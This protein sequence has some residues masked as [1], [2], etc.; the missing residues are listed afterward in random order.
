V[1]RFT[2]QKSAALLLFVALTVGMTWPQARHL[3]THVHD[4]D[5]SL[6]SIWRIAWIAHA[7]AN[8]PADLLDANIFH[9][10]SRTL[11]Y[12]DAVL[13]Q[14]VAAAPLIWSG[15]S[16]IATYNALILLSI[17]VSGW[18]M[19]LYAAR[20][21]GSSAAGV[22][23][24]VIYAFVPYRF[25][26][27]NHLEL[28]ATFFLPLSLL[29]LERLLESRTRRDAAW[30][31]LAVVGQVYSG[32]Y[33]AVFLTTALAIVV[34]L[35][36]TSVSPAARAEI[37]RALIAPTLV[38]IV[39]VVPY[40][41][42]Y[43]SN[44]ASLGERQDSEIAL[45]SATLPNYLAATPENVIHGG[46]SSP[47]GRSERRLFPGVIATA[48]AVVGLFAAGRR[49][50]TLAVCA[51]IGLVLSLGFNTPLYDWIRAVVVPYR[52]L[53]APARAAILVFVAIAGLAAYG[54]ARLMRGRSDRF[55]NATAAII[56]GALLIEYCAPLRSWLVLPAEP[57]RVYRWLASQPPIVVAEFPFARADRLDIIH[58]GVYMFNSI[59]H[60]QPIVNG[61]SGFFPRSFMEMSEAMSTFPDARAIDY[62]RRRGVDVI[63]VHGALL[64]ERQ[65]SDVTTAL[66]KHPDLEATA[67]FDEPGGTDLVFRLRR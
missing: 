32:I 3:S 45:Y 37:A 54:F 51:A 2:L 8:R 27:Y 47:L 30:L 63:V 7:L 39:V 5:D 66:L 12:S 15:V 19:W 65:R 56:T 13:L 17:A 18:A 60:W 52:G 11:A 59:Y 24:G 62:L 46:W 35:R 16:A 50:N 25:D 41:L 42:V 43:V 4:S 53:R 14:G 55:T 22:I 58:D 57:P 28:H 48:F 9:P 38:A 33:Y 61:Y 36:L 34:P 26:H 44:R 21:T 40:L 29:A 49:R 23:A 20:V 67:Q 10:E 6:L 1:K 31:A 64:G